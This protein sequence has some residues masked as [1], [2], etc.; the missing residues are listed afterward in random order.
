[1]RYNIF[2]RII[3]YQVIDVATIW[4]CN[5]R[6]DRAIFVLPWNENVRTK[7]KQDTNRN[8]VIWLGYRTDTHAPGFWLV[9]R[10]LGCNNFMPDNFLE[11]SRY[12]AWRHTAEH[13]WP[14]EQ[15][16][17][18]IKVFETKSPSFDLFNHWLIKQIRNTFKKHFSR[19]HENHS[20]ISSV[21]KENFY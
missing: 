5:C 11:I 8:R 15:C 21:N 7:Q 6:I 12:L 10:K 16:L 17:L 13:D 2:L 3:V 1:M 18:P 4:R 14:I 20:I 19:S 9:N